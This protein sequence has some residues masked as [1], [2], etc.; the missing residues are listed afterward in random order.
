MAACYILL[1]RRD[2]KWNLWHWH[3][4]V[5]LLRTLGPWHRSELV[6]KMV[7]AAVCICLHSPGSWLTTD[8][9]WI[10]S[11]EVKQFGFYGAEF[12]VGLAF[13]CCIFNTNQSGIATHP[14]GPFTCPKAHAWAVSTA[15]CLLPRGWIQLME[16]MS[17]GLARTTRGQK[18]PICGQ[19]RGS[20]Q[21]SFQ[22]KV[23]D[24]NYQWL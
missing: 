17:R 8:G 9:R 3:L 12:P 23:Q 11:V 2:P 6:S 18:R 24:C 14:A 16:K 7:T 10:D 20:T 19:R 5:Q 15:A 1:F 4:S 22:W 13:V 21:Q